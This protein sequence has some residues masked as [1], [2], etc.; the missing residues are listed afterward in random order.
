MPKNHSRTAIDR[1]G[2]GLPPARCWLFSL[3]IVASTA[4]AGE[5]P[6]TDLG[7]AVQ[8]HEVESGS[9]LLEAGGTQTLHPAPTVD[10]KV[11][12]RITGMVARVSVQQTFT[13][14]SSQWV[15]GLYVFPLPENAAVDHMWL[16][17]G[18]RRIEGQIKQ[19]QEARKIF[20][21]AKAAGK[22]ASLID[23]ERPNIFTN[24]VANIGPSEIIS[25]TI[26]YQQTLSY[27]KGRFSVRFPMTVGIRYIPGTAVL[28]EFDGGG[29]AYN[30]D[31]VPDASTITPPV[32]NVG[33]GYDNPVD[34]SV[35]LHVGFPV[36]QIAS[37]YHDVRIEDLGRHS[38]R[39]ELEKA[40]RA[41]RDFVL[42]WRPKPELAPRAALFTEDKHGETYGVMMLIPPE[43]EWARQSV[44]PKEL[45]YVVDTSGSMS[46]TS[47]KQAKQALLYGLDRLS[48][49]DSFNVVQ[50]NS[51]T[52]ALSPRAMPVTPENLARA[53]RYVQALQ[54]NGGTEMAGAL[55][56]VL[57]GSEAPNHVRQVIFLT[58]GS[59]GNEAQLFE[60]INERLGDSRLFT[61]GIGSAPN[62]YFMREAA[63]IG[64]GTFTY[65]G[66]VTEVGEEMD[67]LFDK[68]QYPVLAN[69]GLDWSSG[70]DSNYW[71]NPIRDLY[72]HEPL[73]VSFKLE[74]PEASV[75]LSGLMAGKAWRKG[76]PIDGSGTGK[77]LDVLW[78]RNKI[79]SLSQ[80]VSRGV[81]RDEIKT[82][83]TELGLKHHIV[84]R[85]TSLV[86]V[87]VSPSRPP[88]ANAKDAS[89]PLKK[90]Q[91][92]EMRTPPGRLP[93]TATPMLLYLLLGAML[94]LLALVVRRNAAAS[95]V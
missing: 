6:A 91:G 62:S 81:P 29:W 64:R 83:I 54:A 13:N 47:I 8:P 95:G 58:D 44:L 84:T 9:L 52:H 94:S 19:R 45:I 18:E 36:T 39:I 26:E 67:A 24:R 56:T 23:Q 16:T 11:Q 87:E 90:P 76:L 89:I 93:Q 25:V 14:P 86:A 61:V 37:P 17:M 66:N 42:F 60:I 41:D 53:R 34:L 27:E 10:T 33:E 4:F 31:Q 43:T 38:Y 12:M 63:S 78:A 15:N 20:N 22:K 71:P 82:A 74:R 68:L 2:G 65:I 1:H 50:F 32:T 28:S 92:W 48:E 35:E 72:I 70:G 59:V 88:E 7:A 49:R 77:G 80:Q 46:G 69:V 5:P 85:H 40:V 51:Y 79:A 3:L 57:D 21:K 30:T 55:N 75:T 73:I